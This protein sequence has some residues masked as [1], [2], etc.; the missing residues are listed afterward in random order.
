MSRV[1]PNCLN[2]C[3]RHATLE[4]LIWVI[5]NHVD[6]W[7]FNVAPVAPDGFVV[8][9]VRWVTRFEGAMGRWQL[10]RCLFL[11]TII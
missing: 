3:R 8:P 7:V 10:G 9:C 4:G 11:I 2:W 1:L 5:L 6:L